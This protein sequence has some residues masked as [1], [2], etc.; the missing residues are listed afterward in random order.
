MLRLRLR[1]SFDFEV[2]A[3]RQAANLHRR[4]EAQICGNTIL[5]FEAQVSE[6]SE[7]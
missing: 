3:G 4:F 1:M 5:I 2:D 6:F 7:C